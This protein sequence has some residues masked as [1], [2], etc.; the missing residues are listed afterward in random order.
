M[1]KPVP[2]FEMQIH[3]FLTIYEAVE[4]VA[5]TDV[6][7]EDRSV[8]RQVLPL[9]GDTD[10]V[11][12]VRLAVI[13][14]ATSVTEVRVQAQRGAGDRRAQFTVDIGVAAAGSLL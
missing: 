6:G 3:G 7:S 2:Y 4:D 12:K 1:G 8:E 10:V 5:A 11:V 9:G 14:A 13:E